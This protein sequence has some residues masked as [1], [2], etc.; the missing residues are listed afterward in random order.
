MACSVGSIIAPIMGGELT[1]KIGYRS[2]CDCVA[3]FA[4]VCA[5]MNFLLVMLPVIRKDKRAD[6]RQKKFDLVD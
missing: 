6:E 2:T 1:D 5:I 4:F 3:G